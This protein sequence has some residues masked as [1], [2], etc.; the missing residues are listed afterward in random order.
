MNGSEKTQ[1]YANDS[2]TSSSA[3]TPATQPR[4]VSDLQSF[5]HSYSIKHPGEDGKPFTTRCQTIVGG[6]NVLSVAT[7][8]A[9]IVAMKRNMELAARWLAANDPALEWLP[10]WKPRVAVEAKGG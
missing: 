8:R 1:T 4:S 9:Q 10:T 6:L 3:D 7:D 2:A 5:L